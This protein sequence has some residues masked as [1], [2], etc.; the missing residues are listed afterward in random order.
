MSDQSVSD[1]FIWEWLEKMKTNTKFDQTIINSIEQ[2]LD[3]IDKGNL[4]E[5]GLLQ[6]L[7]EITNRMDKNA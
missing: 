4:D 2:N 5:S 3:E 6:A 1:S 7:V